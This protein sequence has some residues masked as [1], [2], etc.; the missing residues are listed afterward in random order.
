MRVVLR[1]VCLKTTYGVRKQYEGDLSHQEAKPS[2]LE[3]VLPTQPQKLGD[4]QQACRYLLNDWRRLE[5]HDYMAYHNK[6]H[7]E[8]DTTRTMLAR[9]LR[10]QAARE[11][12]TALMDKRGMRTYAQADINEVLREAPHCLYGGA[13]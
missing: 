1:G 10:Q 3:K 7:A 2:A 4:W 9:L 8:S 5:K 6:L 12:Y 11:Q 13:E